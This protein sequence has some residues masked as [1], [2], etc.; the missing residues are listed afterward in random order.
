MTVVL[1]FG[2]EFMNEPLTDYVGGD[3]LVF[4]WVKTSDVSITDLDDFSERA[5]VSEVNCLRKYQI[6][7]KD[8]TFKL[9]IDDDDLRK[10]ANKFLAERK[11]H[12]YVETL[13]LVEKQLSER[14]ELDL[15]SD[16]EDPDFV[17][18][19]ELTDSDD[20]IFENNIVNVASDLN[21]ID[22]NNMV[23]STTHLTIPVE[24]H[25]EGEGV[26]VGA[27]VGGESLGEENDSGVEG[28][29]DIVD[30][31]DQHDFDENRISDEDNDESNY[32]IFNPETTFNP[33]FS[34]S[35]IFTSKLEFKKAAQSHAIKQKRN[36]H[37]PKNDS[38]RIYA[39]CSD[40]NCKWGINALKRK[41][42][43][44]FQIRMYEPKHT[45]A[46][47]QKVRNLTST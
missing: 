22:E 5:G 10:W 39:R 33:E 17:I 6:R 47:T 20:D 31:G 37:F 45:C 44:T 32:P 27:D 26:G 34:L 23:E 38:R 29:P 19:N 41:N 12:I 13:P 18:G 2:G 8:K 24:I 30:G 11:I 35:Q 14:V 1:H 46:P 3:T 36:I 7:L 28:D 4:D 40:E 15:E 43:M 42:S 16:F 9:C 25:E 21:E